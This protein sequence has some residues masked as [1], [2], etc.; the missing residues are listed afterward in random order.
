M[1]PEGIRSC[2]HNRRPR[3]QA[4][5]IRGDVK[6]TRTTSE[7]RAVASRANQ[8][9]RVRE[10][11]T[12]RALERLMPPCRSALDRQVNHLRH[13]VC[14]YK[15]G[16]SRRLRGLH[17]APSP[18]QAK[19]NSLRD[20]SQNKQLW[21]PDQA[22][23]FL[24]QIIAGFHTHFWCHDLGVTFTPPYICRFLVFHILSRLHD[25]LLNHVVCLLQILFA[26]CANTLL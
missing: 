18:Q 2:M 25:T 8:Y 24:G 11:P 9:T 20:S 23:S 3:Q 21:S 15:H 13:M 7:Y 1:R 19:L 5:E 16:C 10:M 26:G 4:L 17:I 12:G 6:P 22:F 14:S